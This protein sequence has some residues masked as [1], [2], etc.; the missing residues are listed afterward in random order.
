MIFQRLVRWLIYK[1][2]KNEIDLIK[3][4]IRIGNES[5]IEYPI[6][7]EGEELISIGDNVSILA[8]SRLQTY[9]KLLSNP[10]SITIGD[11]CYLCYRLSM[12]AGGDI[13]IEDNVVMASGVSIISYNHG[14]NPESDIPYMN[15]PLSTGTIT[16]QSNVWI[17]EGVKV[18]PNV[19]I[20]HDS[21]IG[22]GSVVTKSIPPYSV[23]VGNPAVVIKEYDFGEHVWKRKKY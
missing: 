5:T 23:A 22:A 10:G 4:R 3:R 21:V 16:I 20:G 19:V 18:L 8:G 6:V 13:I 1:Y 11:N 12:Q 2:K 15:Q 9:P 14:C 17:G 7:V